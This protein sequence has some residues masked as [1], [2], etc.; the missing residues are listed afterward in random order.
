MEYIIYTCENLSFDH[1]NTYSLTGYWTSY[2]TRF[3]ISTSF[4]GSTWDTIQAADGEGDLVFQGNFDPTSIVT[5]TL[6]SAI[7]TRF[8]RLNVVTFNIWP[9][10]KWAIDGCPIA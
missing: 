6:P 3:S 10:L 4:D 7:V 8:V 2:T 1:D 5:S 9:L